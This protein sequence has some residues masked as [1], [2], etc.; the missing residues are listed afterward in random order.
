MTKHKPS[1]TRREALYGEMNALLSAGVDFSNAFALLIDAEERG[2]VRTLL[3]EL[4]ARVAE[5]STLQRAMIECGAFPPLDCG[6]VDI[7]EQTGRLPE[8]LEFLAD[9]YRK[10]A[11]QR[12]MVSSALTYPTVVLC[13]AAAVTAFMLTVVVPMFEQ[14]YARMGG[15]LPA[16][17]RFVT[18]LAARFPTYAAIVAAAAIIAAVAYR[19]LRNDDR[20]R[21][22]AGAILLK[23]PAAGDMIRKNNQARICKLLDLL[24]SSGVPLLTGVEMIAEA[25]E[26]YPYR[27][28]LTLMARMLEQGVSFSD[29]M[30]KFPDLYGRRLAALVRVGE[31]TNRL[32]EML[33]RQ[34]EALTDE[35]EHAIRRT[36]AVAEPA[37]ILLVGILVAVILISMY[38][39]MFK[40]GGIMG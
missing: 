24:C 31:Q 34:G 21:G 7:G 5:G 6:V 22:A 30:T 29:A 16:L 35:L 33:R 17:T 25:V 37:L 23:L 18:A 9:Y 20:A 39:P 14:V 38:L 10:R 13:T 4:Y 8:A 32:R 36:G 27:R 15:E 12:R 26:F 11:A 2:A 28:S 3:E 40:L 19:R 1:D